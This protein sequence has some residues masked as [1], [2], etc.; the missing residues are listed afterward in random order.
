M[1]RRPGDVLPSNKFRELK[2]S[3]NQSMALRPKGAEVGVEKKC[4]ADGGQVEH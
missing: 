4:F 2:K 1:R 3:A